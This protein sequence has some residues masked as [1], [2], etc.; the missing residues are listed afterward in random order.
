MNLK[1]CGFDNYYQQQITRE[2]IRIGLVPG[3][4]IESHR[5]LYRIITDE[6]ETTARLKG[7]YFYSGEKSILY[8]TVGDYVL[9]KSNTLGDDII[10]SVLA[11][12]TFFSRLNPTPGIGEQIVAANFDYVFI[13][14]SLNY[15]FNIRRLERYLAAAWQSGG[16]P[17]II[18]TKADLVH[19]YNSQIA[20]VLEIAPGVPVIPISSH[21]G[22]GLEELNKYL[23]PSKTIVFLGS[24]GIG[25][26]SLVNALTNDLI[27]PVKEIRKEDSRGRHTTTHRQMIRLKNDVFIIDTP[28]MRE[29]GMWDV[30]SGI[31]EAFADIE[32]LAEQCKFT[33]CS[34]QKEPGC[35]IQEALTNGNL[36]I[37]RWKSY[38]K[39]KKETQYKKRK[40]L[41]K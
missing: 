25:K 14:T 31:Q 9:V 20:E 35:A 1:N 4:I 30:T 32:N 10:Y 21:T 39:L 16:S 13:M 12:K 36:D 3:R 17:V 18:L 8:P 27:M 2:D 40:Q 28:G 6:G 5:E 29:L 38:C 41:H 22:Y 15:D 33:N 37:K 7:S 11:R 26:S 34:H 24:S 19:D 23:Q